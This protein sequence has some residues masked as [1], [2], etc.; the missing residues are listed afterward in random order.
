MGS[1][2]FFYSDERKGSYI[3]VLPV[4]AGWTVAG[5]LRKARG[6]SEL[7]RAVC[8]LTTSPG[9]RKESATENIP[10]LLGALVL[11]SGKGEKVR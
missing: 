1:A 3:M 10:P 7:H 2:L 5:F 8:W 11:G 4:R 6:K 9:D